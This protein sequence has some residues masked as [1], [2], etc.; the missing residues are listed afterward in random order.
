MPMTCRWISLVGG[1]GCALALGALASCSSVRTDEGLA[2]LD[3]TASAGVPPFTTARFSVAGLPAIPAHE[4]AYDGKSPLKFG[5]YLPGP[6]GVVRVTGQA[7]SASCVVG[8]GTANVTIQLG[9]ISD[10]VPLMIQPVTSI[11]PACETSPDASTDA[12]VDAAADALPDVPRDGSQDTGARTDGPTTRPD[13]GPP[14]CLIATK[15]CTSSSMCCS[16]L[17]CATTSLGQVCCGNFEAKCMRPGGEDCCGQLECING[18]CCLPATYSC[19]GTSCCAG[20]VCGN[21]SLGHVCCGNAGAPCIRPDGADC[22][23][24]LRCVGNVC[25]K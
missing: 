18:G 6:N 2:M 22:C 4:V 11:D 10:A 9:H 7:L 23:G 20:L 13:S 14:A 8:V 5:Y 17:S 25:T 1:L 3:V 19:T 15:A 16:G 12:P 24:A 21:T